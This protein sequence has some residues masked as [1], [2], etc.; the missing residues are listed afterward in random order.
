MSQ[1]SR[2]DNNPKSESNHWNLFKYLGN[3]FNASRYY[4]DKDFILKNKTVSK[5]IAD[6]PIK[7]IN[8]LDFGLDVNAKQD[9]FMQGAMAAYLFFSG[10]K[11]SKQEA[12]YPVKPFT[13]SGF[14]GFNWNK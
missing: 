2:W 6:V 5:S 10:D 1:F 9:L 4:Y 11:W 14:K 3:L 8:W 12:E 13:Y 7:D